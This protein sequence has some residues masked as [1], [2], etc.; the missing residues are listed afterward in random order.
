[1][2]C[3]CSSRWSLHLYSVGWTTVTASCNRTFTFS[4]LQR[5]V[6]SKRRCQET[7]AQNT[8]PMPSFHL[9]SSVRECILFKI[10]VL[11]YQALHSSSP[12]YMSLCFTRVVDM[13]SVWRLSL[14]RSNFWP[15]TCTSASLQ[16]ANGLF[17]LPAST[18][19][20]RIFAV[21]AEQRAWG[22]GKRNVRGTW[23]YVG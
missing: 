16:S 20:A 2:S 11:T 10:A 6:C 18:V 23:G 21:G 3:P 22:Q 8:L 19:S 5:L 1:M 7:A 9:S 12:R 4:P 13:P 15:A 14:L 17:Q